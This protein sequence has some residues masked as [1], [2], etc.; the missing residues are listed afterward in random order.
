MSHMTGPERNRFD[1]QQA[2]R[3]Q[4]LAGGNAA[5]GGGGSHAPQFRAVSAGAPQS[6]GGTASRDRWGDLAEDEK[7]TIEIFREASPSVVHI[8]TTSQRLLRQGLRMRATGDSG[9]ERKRL[10]L[11]R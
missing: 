1:R 3:G 8:T 6:V 7:A 9:R 10:H 2:R 5:A 4:R 11:G